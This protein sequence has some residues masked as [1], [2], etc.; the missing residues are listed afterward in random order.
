MSDYIFLFDMDS[1]ITK[2][3]V[4]PTIANEIGRLQEM[5]ELTEATMRGELPFKTSFLERVKI[6][7]DISVKKVKKGQRH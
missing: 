6:L 7:G 5:R 3:E 2:V 1:T 4:L